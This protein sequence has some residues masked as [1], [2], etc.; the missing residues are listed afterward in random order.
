MAIIK[1]STNNKCL[2]GC[3]EKR[4]LLRCW[5]EHKLYQCFLRSVSQG[6]RNT[7]R[8]KQIEPN[9]TYKLLH[10]KGNHLKKKRK[11]TKRQ[12]TEILANDTTEKRLISK[13]YKQLIQLNH[14]KNNPIEKWAEDLN[15]HFSKEDIQLSVNT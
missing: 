6:N 7:N 9:Q 2:R 10:R 13:I 12:P 5:K 3:G 1:K 8:N 11:K 4:T 15:R 14:K